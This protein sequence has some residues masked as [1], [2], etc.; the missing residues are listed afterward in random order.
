MKRVS[1]VLI[2]LAFFAF[3]MYL[4]G[5]GA[6]EG[7]ELEGLSAEDLVDVLDDP[8]LHDGAALR[9][10]LM[11]VRGDFSFLADKGMPKFVAALKSNTTRPEGKVCL[12]VVLSTFNSK[13]A[14]AVPALAEL[15]KDKNIKVRRNAALAI[16]R[17]GKTAKAA[18]PALIDSH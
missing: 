14:P 4:W 13:A 6:R 18:I 5:S 8:D 9:L 2:G 17:L 7:S 16:Q 15:L 3:G 10:Q 12:C 11:A 1:I